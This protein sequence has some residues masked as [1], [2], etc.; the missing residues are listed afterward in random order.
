MHVMKKIIFSAIFVLVVSGFAS[1]QVSGRNSKTTSYTSTTS[2]KAKKPTSKKAS[3]AKVEST[4]SSTTVISD[5]RKE[6]V[7]D[8][9]LA[10]ETGHEAAPTNGQQFQS[11]KDSANKKRKNH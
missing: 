6:Y 4:N 5:N 9:Q 10:T 11:L 8:G 1:A 7:K 2:H 3:R